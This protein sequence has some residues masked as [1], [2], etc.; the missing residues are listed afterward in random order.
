M[1]VGYGTAGLHLCV[2]ARGIGVGDEVI[3]PSFAFI[4]VANVVRY[5]NAIP[6]FVDIEPDTLN[7]DPSRIETA[8]TP[9]TKAILLVHTF[10]CPAELSEI[11]DIARRHHLYEIEHAC[12]AIGAEDENRKVPGH[13][14][15]AL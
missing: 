3:F 10:G 15:A 9:R 5:E 1:G 4:A 12:E 13:G 8:I 6:V 2:R 7:L 14:H 11:V